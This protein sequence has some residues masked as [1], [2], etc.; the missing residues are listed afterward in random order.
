MPPHEQT[1]AGNHVVRC[2]V[3]LQLRQVDLVQLQVAAG[4][5]IDPCLPSKWTWSKMSR[6]FRGARYEIAIK[7]RKGICKGKVTRISP[8]CSTGR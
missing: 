6:D 2:G 4:L 7:K 1:A 8:G 5:K 3:R